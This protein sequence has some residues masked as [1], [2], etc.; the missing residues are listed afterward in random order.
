[1]NDIWDRVA[2]LFGAYVDAVSKEQL[3]HISYRSAHHADPTSDAC[4]L[5][6][7]A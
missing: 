4:R 6:L 2:E 1:M 7:D 5:K 3:A